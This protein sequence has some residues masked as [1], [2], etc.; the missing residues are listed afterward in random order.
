MS[1]RSRAG[2][3]RDRSLRFERVNT[4]YG[5]S[6][7]LHDATLDVRE[8]EIVALLGRNGAG[9]STLLKT[10][11]RASCRWRR[12]RSNIAGADIARLPAPD[13]ARAGIGYVPQG[14][15]LF[16]GMTR[17]GKP[18]ARPAGAQDRRQQRRGV[19]RGAD[20]RI[21]PAPARAHGRRG[22]LSLRRRAADGRGRA[23]D[24]GQCQPA[25]AR[26]ALRG[27]G[28]GGDPR[29]VQGVRPG[30]GSTSPS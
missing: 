19:G 27:T 21:L 13:I 7:I 29:A 16:A 25:A 2:R 6:H 1:Q 4:F 10:H 11:C 9:K 22:G 14:R 23:R 12:A 26:R 8:G 5:K 18:R 15:G 20:P 17:A 30:C 3:R 28:A 24:V